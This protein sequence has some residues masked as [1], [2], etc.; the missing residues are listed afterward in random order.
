[1]QVMYENLKLATTIST[2]SLYSIV[3]YIWSG[4]ETDKLLFPEFFNLKIFG[5]MANL[6]VNHAV[7]V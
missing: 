1:M 7:P 2:F 5:D 3:Y 6:S 4:P